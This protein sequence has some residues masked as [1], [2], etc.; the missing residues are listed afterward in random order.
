VLARVKMS[1]TTVW[2]MEN[3]GEFPRRRQIGG[4]VVG[5]LESEVD[6]W[7]RAR[8]TAKPYSKT[9]RPI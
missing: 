4:G 5:W 6:Q 3:R 8:P 2:R 1:R 9:V 7:I